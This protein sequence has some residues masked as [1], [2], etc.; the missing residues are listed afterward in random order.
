MRAERAVLSGHAFRAAAGATLAFLA[1]LALVGALTVQAV[2]AAMQDEIGDQVREEIALLRSVA[3]GGGEGAVVEAIE[4][5][6][7]SRPGLPHLVGLFGPGG[8][9]L[10]GTL[11]RPPA[12]E[13][14]SRLGYDGGTA[15][16]RTVSLEPPGSPRPMRLSVGRSLALVRAATGR[17]VVALS[18]GGLAVALAGLAI[19]YAVSRDALRRL[20]RMSDALE[21]VGWGDLAARLPE[22]GSGDQIDRVAQLGNAHLDR[23]ERLVGATRRTASSMAHELRSPLNRLS[24]ALQR[25]EGEP[26]REGALDRVAEAYREADALGRTFDTLLRIAR[27]EGGAADPAYGPIALDDLVAAM[28]DALADAVEDGGRRLVRAPRAGAV[29]ASGDGDMLAQALA[30]LVRNV[31]RHT[32]PGTEVTIGATREG[33]SAVLFV[34]DDGPGM[35]ADEREVAAEPFRRFGDPGTGEGAA[36]GGA[37]GAGNGGG[38]AG[39]GLGLALVRAIAEHHGGALRLE[40]AAPGLDARIVLPGIARSR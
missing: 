26:T 18:I 37:G 29:V 19:G 6:T 22:N 36:G 35:A 5:L 11:A 3:A 13:G 24:I 39:A 23:L 32:P 30:N 38:G 7:V 15:L 33:G 12:A 21:R 17:M 14:W 2:R 31:E 10:A 34:R 27:L 9:R 40:D 4:A 20:E 25:A 28:H 8:S 16:V 1:V